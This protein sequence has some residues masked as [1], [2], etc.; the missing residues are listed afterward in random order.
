MAR[1]VSTIAGGRVNRR[2]LALAVILGL[3]FAV[4]VYVWM[5]QSGEE[6]TG[7]G[8]L[9]VVV[10][11]D[12]IPAGER[13]TEAMITDRRLPEN[14][15]GEGAITRTDD[16]LGKVVRSDIQP[17]EPILSSRLVD[18][19]VPSNDAL[20]YVI[21]EGQR[22]MAIKT[23]LVIGAGGL[24]LPGDHVD[25][26]T[27]PA[28]SEQQLEQDH[29]GAILVAENVEVLAVQQTIVNIAP[30]APGVQDETGGSQEPDPS[31]STRVRASD[32]AEN[33]E[34]TTVTLLLTPQQSAQIFCAE[35]SGTLRLLVRAYGDDSPSDLPPL[36]CILRAAKEQ[37]PAP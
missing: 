18:T 2:F 24:V 33:P 15:L 22:G 35:Q 12:F 37:A 7:S 30:A 21:E 16:V 23:D 17:N 31:A 13:I 34:A 6:S 5:S 27:T 4:L 9:S 29:P 28:D 26:I 10:A 36:D 1:P 32:A 8:R 20:S 19:T 25:I 11:K 14:A 3:I